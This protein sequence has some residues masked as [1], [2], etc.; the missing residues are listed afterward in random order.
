MDLAEQIFDVIDLRSF[1]SI[2]YWI[3][4]A[5]VWST[6][7][8]WVL[9]VPYDMIL[10]A[11]RKGG[12]AEVDLQD[13]VRVNVTR[14]LY[15]GRESG[16]WLFGFVVFVHTMLLTLALWYDIELAQGIALI[17]LP[18]TLVGLLAMSSAARIEAQSPA[19]E[20]LLRLLLRHR[21]W[22]QVIGMASIFVTALYGM[23]HNLAVPNF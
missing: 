5:V 18:L 17:A 14:I 21:L 8:H 15:I 2:W 1:S 11:R 19:G 10:R 12:Q 22:T 13:I 7:S 16:V 4:L 23:W 3:V 20:A 6:A 9:G